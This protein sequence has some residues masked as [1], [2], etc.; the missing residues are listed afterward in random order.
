[1]S[2]IDF[3]FKSLKQYFKL[4]QSHVKIDKYVLKSILKLIF[5][6]I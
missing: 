2:S 1:M 5:I 4:R 3:K 6:I